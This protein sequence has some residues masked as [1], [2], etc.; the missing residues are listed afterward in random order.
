MREAENRLMSPKV[1]H[2]TFAGTNF[3]GSPFQPPYTLRES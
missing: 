3:A 1:H 2:H